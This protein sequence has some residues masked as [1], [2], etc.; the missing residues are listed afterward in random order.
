M[1]VLEVTIAIAVLAM[2]MLSSASAFLGA[3][4]G[5]RDARRT[6]RA[7]VYLATVMEDVQATPYDS[8][9]SLNGNSF[10]DQATLARSAFVVDVAAFPAAVDLIQVRAIV[11]DARSN[12]ELGRIAT[13]RSRP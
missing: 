3:M 10:H 9:L 4:N 12:R 6:S 11:R 2:L 1:T 7:S 13:L 8:L 5:A